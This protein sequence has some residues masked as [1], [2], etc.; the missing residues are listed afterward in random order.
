[1]PASTSPLIALALALALAMAP[2]AAHARVRSRGAQGAAG[3]VLA[4]GAREAGGGPVGRARHG[5]AARK[6]RASGEGR[7]AAPKALRRRGGAK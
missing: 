2:A 6:A 7:R 1:M 5:Q 4:A 3:G